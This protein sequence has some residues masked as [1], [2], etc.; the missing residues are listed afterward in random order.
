MSLCYVLEK[1]ETS[2]ICA[3]FSL[4]MM[5]QCITLVLSLMEQSSI[6]AVIAE[7]PSS[8]SW[9]KVLTLVLMISVAH[10]WYLRMEVS[11]VK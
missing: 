5:F 4:M 6:Q 9:D 2:E 8:S 1:F 10:V 11:L 3:D 7:H